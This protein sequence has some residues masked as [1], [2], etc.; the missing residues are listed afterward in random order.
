MINSRAL[1][2]A[3][4]KGGRKVIEAFD[5]YVNDPDS[6][7]KESIS[8]D[9]Q[10]GPKVKE[11]SVKFE[12]PQEPTI[13]RTRDKIIRKPKTKEKIK[14]KGE[15]LDITEKPG[16]AQQKYDPNFP[17]PSQFVDEDSTG[18]D[19]SPM[20]RLSDEFGSRLE[21]LGGVGE[22]RAEFV[23]DPRKLTKI[24]KK[25][26]NPRTGEFDP[27]FRKKFIKDPLLRKKMGADKKGF[28]SEP[29]FETRE[30][31][32]FRSLGGPEFN[33]GKF[34][35]F[36][37]FQLKKAIKESNQDAIKFRGTEGAQDTINSNAMLF[38]FFENFSKRKQGKYVQRADKKTGK[39]KT[40]YQQKRKDDPTNWNQVISGISV[41]SDL[42]RFFTSKDFADVKNRKTSAQLE[43]GEF[44]G[45]SLKKELK[46]QPKQTRDLNITALAKVYQDLLDPNK[47]KDQITKDPIT[48]PLFQKFETTLGKRDSQLTPK[49]SDY[50]DLVLNTI[51]ENEKRK[52]KPSQTKELI[53][54]L[55]EGQEEVGRTFDPTLMKG[56]LKTLG[57]EIKLDPNTNKLYRAEPFETRRE[58][59]LDK[60]GNPILDELEDIDRET[61]LSDSLKELYGEDTGVQRASPEEINLAKA[62]SEAGMGV[63]VDRPTFT[64]FISP[65][66]I[67]NISDEERKN[68]IYAQN[69]YKDLFE[70]ARKSGMSNTEARKYAEEGTLNTMLQ[71]TGRSKA[72]KI[73]SPEKRFELGR[74]TKDKEKRKEEVRLK[75]S[76]E[77]P[78][79]RDVQ[80]PEEGPFLP[81]L[82]EPVRDFDTLDLQRPNVYLSSEDLRPTPRRPLDVDEYT[83]L[84]VGEKKAE[85]PVQTQL[86]EYLIDPENFK[87]LEDQKKLLG[88]YTDIL[89]IQKG[90]K[91]SPGTKIDRKRLQD[92]LIKFYKKALKDSKIKKDVQ[93]Q[94][95]ILK[96]IQETSADK[97]Q[98]GGLVAVKKNKKPIP[99]ILQNR[100]LRKRNKSRP[101]GVGKALRGYGAVNHA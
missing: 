63:T 13:I 59:K 28:V 98:T 6:Y 93:E 22:G 80:V 92:K 39:K 27:V 69:L 41:K 73:F 57:K 67:K 66:N 12:V 89:A 95:R 76:F 15:M 10:K 43:L 61:A 14:I 60:E 87:N 38:K 88:V 24:P 3:L 100:I 81:G 101:L 45:R 49:R 55:K 1:Q 52:R 84:M 47:T 97:F 29:V 70:D 75:K 58:I 82:P 21:D 99:K 48:G 30:R 18:A 26:F 23:F 46:E 20:Q 65:R 71:V 7:T 4:I 53:S 72:S 83:Q 94:D 77:Q 9:F 86:T 68:I 31:G 54:L 78:E 36:V 40:V 64:E 62:F 32:E 90:L 11:E 91:K 2:R 34:D 8:K 5:K 56:K 25:K 50:L 79:L 51:A 96:L 35:T 44:G 85:V 74:T 33:K 19:M 37:K 16:F 42:A 17:K